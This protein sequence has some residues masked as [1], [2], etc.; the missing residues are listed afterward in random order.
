MNK[1]IGFMTILHFKYRTL[2]EE[3]DGVIMPFIL[4]N[5]GGYSRH[6]LNLLDD[7]QQ[8]GRTSGDNG[9]DGRRQPVEERQSRLVFSEGM[10]LQ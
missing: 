1:L 7:I 9:A 2:A 4:E 10:Y 5:G 3:R 6:A 8:L